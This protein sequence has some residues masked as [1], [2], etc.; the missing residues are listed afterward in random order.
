MH[1]NIEW[2]TPG[3]A[4]VS[5][6][7][8]DDKKHHNAPYPGLVL[9]ARHQ[10]KIARVKVEAYKEGVS[11]GEVVALIDPHSGERLKQHGKLELG[12]TV[13]LPDDKR[14]FEPQEQDD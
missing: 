1:R 13:R 12:D 8:S 14:S 11:I 6:Y 7:Y 3:Q 2:D 9:S 5:Q 10:G 4:S